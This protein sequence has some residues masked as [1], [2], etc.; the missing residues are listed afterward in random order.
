MA[1]RGRV[2]ALLKILPGALLIALGINV[3]HLPSRPIALLAT[4]MVLAGIGW[5][6]VGLLYGVSRGA[7]HRRRNE[8]ALALGST[9]LVVLV[10]MVGG[11]LIRVGGARLQPEGIHDPEL[12]WAPTETPDRVGMRMQKVDPKKDHILIVG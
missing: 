12:G 2:R 6:V 1:E 10:V 7:L 9:T 4:A 5:L 3:A 11:V 8:I